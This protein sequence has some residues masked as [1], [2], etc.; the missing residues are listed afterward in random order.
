MVSSCSEDD[1]NNCPAINKKPYWNG[2]ASDNVGYLGLAAICALCT[3]YTPCPDTQYETVPGTAMTDRTCG[4]LTQCVAGT[5][6]ESVAPTMTSDRNC[7]AVSPACNT[8]THYESQ[9]PTA[10]VDRVCSL[11]TECAEGETETAAPTATSD[12]VCADESATGPL[13]V[14]ASTPSVVLVLVAAL[15]SLFPAIGL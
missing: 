10:L 7:S 14:V 11:I 13:A 5:T 2:A 8:T 4:D 12:R 15:C 1:P 6:Y 9:S 3:P